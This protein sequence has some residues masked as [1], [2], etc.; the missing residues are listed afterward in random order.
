MNAAGCRTA[1]DRYPV[2]LDGEASGIDE[3]GNEVI[4]G[5]T[6]SLGHEPVRGPA[7]TLLSEG[8]P[9][10]FAEHVAVPRRVL[11]PKPASSPTPK[12]PVSPA[13]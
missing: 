2:I 4:V 11:A 13:P 3:E 5:T 7:H 6:A 1:A 8:A 12:P 9:G 10:T